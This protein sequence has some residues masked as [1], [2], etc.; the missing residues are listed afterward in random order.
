MSVVDGRDQMVVHELR[1]QVGPRAG[2]LAHLT[3][4]TGDAGGPVRNRDTHQRRPTRVLRLEG[5][6]L[7]GG[8]VDFEAGRFLRRLVAGEVNGLVRQRVVSI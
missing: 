3:T 4:P 5:N 2:V 1:R 8:L 7:R 6:K